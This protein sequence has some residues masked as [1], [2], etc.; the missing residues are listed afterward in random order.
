M[1]MGTLGGL[2]HIAELVAPPYPLAVR[3]LQGPG[4]LGRVM[5]SPCLFICHLRTPSAC[6]GVPLAAQGM[7][8]LRQ[9]MPLGLPSWGA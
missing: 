8:D 5:G 4:E 1:A 2:R 3:K 9:G 7:G 6:L